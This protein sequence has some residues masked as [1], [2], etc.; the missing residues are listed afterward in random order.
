LSV[1]TVRLNELEGCRRTDAEYYQP[2]NMQTR[3]RVASSPYPVKALSEVSKS[4]I[5]F[6]AYSLCNAISFLEDGVPFLTGKEIGENLIQWGTARHI[7]EEQHTNLLWKSQI[8]EGQVLI[9]MAGR[10]GVSCVFDEGFACNSSQDVAKV[11][12]KEG[13]D[14]YYVSAFLNSRY[15]SAQLLGAQTGSVQHHTNLGII[16]TMRII[17]LPLDQQE[18]LADVVRQAKAA[19][20]HSESLYAQA[21]TLLA[22]ELGLDKL[23]LSESL[24]SVRHFSE[25]TEARRADAEYY[26]QKYERLLEHLR[27]TGQAVRLGDWLHESL[28]RGVQPQYDDEGEILV[29]NSQ[30]VGKTYIELEDNRLTTEEFCEIGS[31]RRARV[32][33]NDVLLNSTGYITIGRCQTL[34]EDV[35][36]IVDG[37]VTIVRPKEGLDPVYLGLFL[38]ALPGQMQTERGWTGSSGQIELRTDV[39]ADFLVWKAPVAIQRQIRQLVEQSHQARCDAKRLLAEAKAEV[40]RMIEQFPGTG[41]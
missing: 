39:I 38:N 32:R 16:K 34:L 14:P 8:S 7:S 4:I 10:L 19:R 21:Q 37:H 2:A 36:A 22:A 29:I 25:V 13:I 31:N 35:K 11:T 3:H 5:N 30:H 15:G 26:R 41:V 33:Q 9:S 28:K 27:H 18:R 24:Y 40:E 20:E 1:S 23:D 17:V 12:L 6:G